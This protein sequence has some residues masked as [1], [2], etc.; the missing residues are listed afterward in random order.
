[1][2]ARLL[3]STL[4]IR[5]PA[6]RGVEVTR[7]ALLLS[8]P[9]ASNI[10]DAPVG[11][12]DGSL[13]FEEVLT[14]HAGAASHLSQQRPH[15]YPHLPASSIMAPTYLPSVRK[16]PVCRSIAALEAGALLLD[17]SALLAI[18]GGV[19][20]HCLL[21]RMRSS[22]SRITVKGRVSAGSLLGLSARVRESP[23][24]GA[25]RAMVQTRITIGLGLGCRLWSKAW[26][27]SGV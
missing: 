25:V 3:T 24:S 8:G 14:P 20:G 2:R 15:R 19:R 9:L 27:Q 5:V 23:V 17:T 11:K 18:D 13:R 16:L 4:A 12:G 21:Q 6:S 7:E 26:G 22:T 1:M 10:S